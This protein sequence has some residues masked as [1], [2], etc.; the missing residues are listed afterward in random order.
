PGGKM[1]QPGG[2]YKDANCSG[3][4]AFH[5]FGWALLI[6]ILILIL[7]SFVHPGDKRQRVLINLQLFVVKERIHQIRIKRK[8]KIRSLGR[9][10]QKSEMCLA[11]KVKLGTWNPERET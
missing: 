7:I 10:T 11:P 6:L 5:F 2:K 1:K 9:V 3:V 4:G 8:I